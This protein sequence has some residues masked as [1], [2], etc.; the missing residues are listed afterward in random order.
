[1]QI[2]PVLDL[3]KGQVVRGI[4]G[5]RDEYRP[6]VS[7]LT[8]SSDPLDVAQALR[9]YFG[10]TELYLADLDAILG[11]PPACAI[12]EALPQAGFHLWVDAGI[13]QASD[14]ETLDKAKVKTIVAGLETLAGPEVLADLLAKYGSERIVFS[15]DLKAGC[16]LG[17]QDAWISANPEEIAA[18][19]YALGVR[20]L[21]VLDLANVGGGKGTGTLA[22]CR[23]LS[24]TYPQMRLTAGGGIA[25]ME[26]VRE[27]AACGVETV[28]VASA[29]HDGR[30]TAV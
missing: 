7:R 23:K 16:V 1:M 9:S 18:Q 13:R 15:L 14:A 11:Q 29:L 17:V 6:I 21:L 2:L 4:G 25:G 19:A 28:L 5:R 3:L 26:D 27:L 30:I 8:S 22:L 24:K 10:F 12:Y 20:R